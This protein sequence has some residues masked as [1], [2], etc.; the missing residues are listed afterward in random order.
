MYDYNYAVVQQTTHETQTCRND[1]VT[2]ATLPHQNYD[3]SFTIRDRTSYANSPWAARSGNVGNDENLR[4]SEIKYIR[5]LIWF[6]P[7][8]RKHSHGRHP[9]ARSIF[10]HSAVRYSPPL[11]IISGRS[12]DVAASDESFFV[13]TFR[14]RKSRKLWKRENCF[15]S[16]RASRANRHVKFRKSWHPR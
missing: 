11:T 7:R 3:V 8:V 12:T 6:S 5:M 15:H 4:P 1:I 13:R 9:D 2:K 10:M 16:C 14:T